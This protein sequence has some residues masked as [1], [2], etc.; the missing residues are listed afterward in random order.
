VTAPRLEVDLGKVADNARTL[1]GLL[2][3]AGISVTG[4]TKAF[5][6]APEVADAML[7]GGVR[8]LGD[9]RVENLESLARSGVR[10]PRTLLRSPM[11]SQVD[12]VVAAA[13][14]SLN[15]EL[16]VIE[17]LST[18]AQARN[19]VHGVIVMVELGDLREGV[20]AD[21][22]IDLVRETL[23]FPGIRVVGIG[24]N[25]ACR[26]GVAPDAEK[27]A[28]LSALAASVEDTFGLALD[29][30]SGGNSANLA[31]ALSGVDTG[32][33]DDLR[34]G[35]AI[36][37]GREPLHRTPLRGLHTDAVRLVA[38]VIESRPKPA[39]AWGDIARSAF[40]EVVP[41]DVGGDIHQA[42]VALGRADTDPDGLVAPAGIRILGAS[43]DH[44]VL[45]AG[46]LACPVGSEVTFEPDYSALV[47]AAASPYVTTAFLAPGAASGSPSVPGA[48]Q[49]RR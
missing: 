31:W 41:V 8:G 25:L 37:L 42:L 12:R 11:P 19:R 38:E 21:D 34:L 29:V 10:A 28:E 30:V 32:R 2:A 6:G 43:S 13:D 22:L 48:A 33:V 18:A 35:E 39:R 20:L 16:S 17:Q 40:G 44:L 47:R 46:T 24:T 5:L 3:P 36:L 27:M 9:S 23:R 1:V 4:V 7:R 49:R 15:S 14:T 45:D 26:S